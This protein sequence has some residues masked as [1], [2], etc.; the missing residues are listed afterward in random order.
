MFDYDP[1]KGEAPTDYTG[2]IFAAVL[3]P[4]FILFICLGKADMGFTVFIV[5]GMVMFAIKL[6]WKLRK[7]AWFWLALFLI[8]L[9]H[10]P[11][12]FVVQWPHTNV[13][14]IAYSL[15][16]GI[17]DFFLISGALGLAEKLF[18][19]GSSLDEGDS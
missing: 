9:L 2:L 13:P 16:L 18:S 8:L 1:P 11:L 17:V 4:V 14:T 12:L 15:P 10:I 3:A 6:R 5:L 7:H 19:K